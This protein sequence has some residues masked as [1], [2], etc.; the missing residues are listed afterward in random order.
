MEVLS[1][2][3]HILVLED[4]VARVQVEHLSSKIS[5]LETNEGVEIWCRHRYGGDGL[6]SQPDLPTAATNLGTRTIWFEP[7]CGPRSQVE[8]Q[9]GGRPHHT[10]SVEEED[11]C[12]PVIGPSEP[13]DW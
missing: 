1:P 5:N 9:E 13:L 11:L 7:L 2:C 6:Q 12:D 3:P 10:V 8:G 4:D